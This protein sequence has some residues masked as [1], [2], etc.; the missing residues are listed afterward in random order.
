MDQKHRVILVEDHA[1]I[2]E[3]IRALLSSFKEFDVVGEAEDGYEG[4]KIIEK[5]QPDLVLTDLSM[6]RMNGIE[7]ITTIKR[8]CPKTKVIALTVHR[9]EDYALQTLQAGANGYVLKEANSAE[10]L[11]AIREVLKGKRYLSPEISAKLGD[12]YPEGRK[13]IPTHSRWDTLTLRER[14]IIKL[15]VEGYTSKEIADLLCI[16][17]KTVGKHR[18]N[19]MSKLEIHNTAALVALA[20]ERGLISEQSLFPPATRRDARK[21]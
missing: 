13:S 20:A 15:V 3:G 11:L 9:H 2:R 8:H 12:G 4:I 21:R 18:S 10:L 17:P 7:M 14:E 16:S 1:I 5:L 19:F 6:P